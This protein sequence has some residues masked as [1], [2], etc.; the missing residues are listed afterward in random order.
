MKK[1]IN[2]LLIV[3]MVSLLV[4][5]EKDLDLVPLDNISEEVFF[6]TSNDFKFW[7]N[8]YYGN[9]T[10]TGVTGTE[11]YADLTTG[12]GGNTISRGEHQ[13]S[14]YDGSW[15]SNYRLI[16]NAN[17]LIEKNKEAD[18]SLKNEVK[19][20]V[21]EAHFFRAWAYFLLVQRFG[22]V[23]VINEVLDT[24]SEAIFSTRTN[25]VE[26]IK[27]AISDLNMAAD[28]CA[29]E[30]ALAAP[31]KGRIS[32]G[33]AFALKSRVA[34]FEGTW[35]KFHNGN[36]GEDFL[37]QA[38]AA[39]NEVISS[40]EYELFYHPAELNDYSYKYL[41][42]LDKVKTNPSSF[43]KADNKES[44]LKRA[45]DA[46]LRQSTR[47]A[48]SHVGGKTPT[49]KL[50]DMYLCLDGLPIDQSDL[51][52]GKDGLATEFKDRDYRMMNTFQIPGERYYSS[53]QAIWNKDWN[54]PDDP[55]RG[56]IY[57]IEFG[58][59]TITGYT[60]YKFN[61]EV[62][63]PVGVD[64][65]VIR[66]AEI[67]LNYIEA[68]YEKEGAVSDA[69]L[70]RSI[71]LTRERG[72]LPALTNAFIASNSLSIREEI[73]RERAVELLYEGFRY[74]D[75]RRWKT[76]ETEIPQAL[77]GVKYLGTEWETHEWSAGFA[78][79]FDADGYILMESASQRTF[80]P[81]K[82]YLFPLPRREVQLNENLVQNPKWE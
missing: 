51:F 67:L 49:R 26:V 74:N 9:L 5:C 76:A 16:R 4:S 22:D 7:A 45:Y 6:K 62:E 15:S 43:T 40:D 57:N 35:Q 61:P 63:L 3:I 30:S 59:R 1:I 37:G 17:I 73:R 18:E 79:D 24:D 13:I 60:T 28:L 44:I 78:G 14:D 39:A 32:Q 70:N 42:M 21:G 19:Q 82:H 25:R 2:R 81:A 47:G 66:Y 29:K 34:L 33:A 36:D 8:Q 31:D 50:A 68:V 10:S 72:G 11:D 75:L 69:E 71:N 53:A 48:A 52:G 20:Y 77:L 41:F 12:S 64:Y 80:D 55:T 23:P 54:N 56:Y 38:I 27:Q 58:A 65:P 46:D